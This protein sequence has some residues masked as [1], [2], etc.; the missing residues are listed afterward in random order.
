MKTPEEK[1][2]YFKGKYDALKEKIA[3]SKIGSVGSMIK[4]SIIDH[5]VRYVIIGLLIVGG[6]FGTYYYVSYKVTETVTEI[7]TEVKESMPHPIDATKKWWKGDHWW[8]SDNNSTK[9]TKIKSVEKVEVKKEISQKDKISW[10]EKLKSLK[11]WGK[12]KNTTKE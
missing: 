4:Q 10:K 7:K 12:D 5:T 1:A 9:D 11:F 2:A 3:E 8:T 6:T